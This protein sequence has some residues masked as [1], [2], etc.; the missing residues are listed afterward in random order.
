MEHIEGNL[1]QWLR[2]ER[3]ISSWEQIQRQL[4]ESSNMYKL[5]CNVLYLIDENA[6]RT[7]TC[8]EHFDGF[9]IKIPGYKGDVSCYYGT[10]HNYETFGTVVDYDDVT[11]TM[12]PVEAVLNILRSPNSGEEV[13][14]QQAC[15]KALNSIAKKAHKAELDV[16]IMIYAMTYA[17]EVLRDID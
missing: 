5:F 1:K 15:R 14:V 6:Y 10:Y 13:P 16:N 8:K 9:I 4:D 11:R 3:N 7:A 12:N 2:T 17:A